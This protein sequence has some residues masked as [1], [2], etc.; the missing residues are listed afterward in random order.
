M[1]KLKIPS[2]I[3]NYLNKYFAMYQRLT[4]SRICLEIASPAY[5][6]LEII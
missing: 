3:R 6:R 4:H 1:K 2:Q 5:L